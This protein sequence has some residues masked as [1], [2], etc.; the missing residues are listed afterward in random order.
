MSEPRFP[1][2]VT[3]AECERRLL[4]GGDESPRVYERRVSAPRQPWE[5][6][7]DEVV[8]FELVCRTCY[9]KAPR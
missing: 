2:G 1:H 6:P 5:A 4:P 7:D 9:G 8:V 3:C